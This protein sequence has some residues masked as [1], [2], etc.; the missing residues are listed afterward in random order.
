MTPLVALLPLVLPL[1]LAPSPAQK[2]ELPTFAMALDVVRIDVSVTRDGVPVK[3]LTASSFEVLDDGVLQKVELM[4]QENLAIH[5]VLALDTSQSVAGPVL[6]RLKAAAHQLVDALG[7]DDSLSLLTFSECTDLAF[8]ASRDRRAAHEAIEL[9]GTRLTTS[10]NDAA[11]AALVVADPAQGR[12]LVLFFSDGEDVGSWTPAEK[13]LRLAKE[14]EVVVH[15]VMPT[16]QP[17]P[18]FIQELT[19]ATGGRI[20]NAT[21]TS[22]LGSVFLNVLDEFRNRYRLQ[23]EPTGVKQAGWHKLALRLKRTDGKLRARPGY[24][25]RV[26]E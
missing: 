24:S 1:A 16:D 25:R 20:W 26:E 15:T 22:G 8:T 12:P 18:A 9:A 13:V 4:G 5:A 23:Y 7:P 14:S 21:E 6:A 17:A 10:L 19:D 2:S 11:L 3:D